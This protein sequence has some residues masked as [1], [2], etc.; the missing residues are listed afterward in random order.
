M[1]EIIK[2][3]NTEM[4]VKQAVKSGKAI[5]DTIHKDENRNGV[6]TAVAFGWLSDNINNG[7]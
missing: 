3:K 4:V 7:R 6:K 2:I 5:F 1:L